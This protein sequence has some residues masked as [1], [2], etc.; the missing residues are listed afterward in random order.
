MS[1]FVD[2]LGRLA[3]AVPV[4]VRVVFGGMMFFHGLDK[5][6]RGPAGFGDFLATEGVPLGELMGWVVSFLELGGGL[7]LV[8]GLLS[9]PVALVLAVELVFA[10]IIVSAANGLIGEEGVGY[11]RDLAYIAGFITV[12]LL[13][14]GRPS[15]DHAL[16]LEL[17]TPVLTESSVTSHRRAATPTPAP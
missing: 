12:A 10:I 5:L 9:R 7:M 11:E 17:A 4:V 15:A 8:L 14:P 2:P 1:V 6:D 16:G 3:G 13:G